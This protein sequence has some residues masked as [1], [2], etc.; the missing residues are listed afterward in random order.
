MV[1]ETDIDEVKRSNQMIKEAV[2][3][4]IIVFFAYVHNLKLIIR[5]H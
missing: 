2:H 3:L 5:I 1:V 4:K